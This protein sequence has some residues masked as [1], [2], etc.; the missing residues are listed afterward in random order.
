MFICWG[1]VKDLIQVLTSGARSQVEVHFVRIERWRLVKSKVSWDSYGQAHP[2]KATPN[3]WNSG[4][5]QGANQQI[6]GFVPMKKEGELEGVVKQK[7][8]SQP[9]RKFLS[10][11][12]MSDRRAKGLCYY[13]DEKYTPDHYLK[14]K[15][16]Q[17]FLL[18]GEE[19]EDEQEVWHDTEVSDV[20]EQTT[21]AQI[22]LN[23]V[24]GS[25]DYT[26]M[27]VRGVHGK[28]SLYILIDTGSTHNFIDQNIAKMLGC[29]V[30]PS[31]RA[32]VSVADGSKIAI[33]GKIDG[34]TWCF[35]QHTFQ[36]EMMVIPLGGH[37]MVLGVQWL[38]KFGPITWN[39]QELEMR[40][41]WE[42]KNITLHGIKKGSVREVK[43][44]RM[45]NK[46]DNDIQLHMIY[47]YEEEEPETVMLKSLEVNDTETLSKGPVEKLLAEF[48]EVFAEPSELPP[49]RANHNHK[50]LLVEGA[51]PVNQK[52]YRYAVHQKNEI[53]KMV[54]ELME[55]G[56]IQASASPYASPVVLVKKKD[57]SWRL[58][59]DYRKLNT[60]TVKDRFPIPLI[61][62]LM[63]ELGGSA[64]YSKIDLRAG[65][66]QVRMEPS[67]IHKTAFKTH[68]GHYEY[69]VMPFGLTNAPATF[70]GL[71][72]SVFQRYLRKFVLIFFDDIL[73]YSE[74]MEEH[75]IHLRI[76]FELMKEN[77]LYA[78]RSKCAF[79][80]SKVEYLGHFI[81]AA[82][83]ST[84][85]AKIKAIV[86]WPQ[87]KTLKALRG[88]L[89]IAGYYRRFV[90]A[91]G[92]IARPLTS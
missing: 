33:S 3:N 15:K 19:M 79:A 87:P 60:L 36:D 8:N 1:L 65:Y 72:N 77:N 37:D 2:R 10:S 53:D 42:N 22:S 63:D 16:S 39:F 71:M 73:I 13:C 74:S 59:V 92:T 90:E 85:P 57:N 84:D 66:H 6:K 54:R 47:V 14:H 35:Q 56:T 27:K 83:I 78:K 4:K 81:E 86:E 30:Q 61:E 88:F 80:T 67:D 21:I 51:N 69:L 26:T 82:G 75:L 64:V 5:Y 49:F 62:D 52:P 29:R 41:K 17:L 18:E 68:S 28:R 23:A 55:A 44:K 45:E 58:C 48:H 38:T 43:A 32:N 25:T 70:Q 20:E 46:K 9:L 7:E 76:V 12:E 11:A 34:F 91:F 89:G 50:I 31:P 24:A 40:F